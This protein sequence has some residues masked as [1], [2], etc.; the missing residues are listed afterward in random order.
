MIDKHM[1][2]FMLTREIDRK[3]NSFWGE[4]TI[5]EQI[6]KT[7]KIIEELRFFFVNGIIII[8]VN[9][10]VHLKMRCRFKH[11]RFRF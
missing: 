11:F 5:N 2:F 10:G 3:R 8:I 1:D 9:T 4:S 7:F 6:N